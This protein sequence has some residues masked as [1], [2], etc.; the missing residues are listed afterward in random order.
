MNSTSDVLKKFFVYQ[1]FF[2]ILLLPQPVFSAEKSPQTNMNNLLHN[3]D[4]F[5]SDNLKK[6][7]TP[8]VAIAIA[9]HGKI[10]SLK[11]YGVKEAGK[12]DL[13]DK[14]TVFRIGSVSKGFAAILTGLLVKDGVLKWDDKVTKYL[15]EFSL[16]DKK[17][18]DNLTIRN[19]LDHTCGLVPHAYDSMIEDNVP[20]EK[21]VDK[22]SDLPV[23]CPVGECYGYQN[24]V[25]SLIG[26]IIKSATGKEYTELLSERILKPLGMN[27]VSFSKKQFIDSKN[28]ASPHDKI[29]RKWKPVSLKETYYSTTPSSG[30]N[31][32]IQDMAQWLLAM[33]GNKSDIIP[34]SVIDEVYTPCITTPRELRRFNRNH[35]IKAAYYGL[36]W[37]IFD[38]SGY[39]LVYH[40]G[41]VNG[42]YAVIALLPGQDTGIVVLQ[43]SSRHNYYVNKFLDMYLN[44][45]QDAPT[46]KTYR[47]SRHFRHKKHKRKKLM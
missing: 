21:I 30:I 44:I 36:G 47:V 4:A 27:T 9:D 23:E 37:R 24:V 26:D 10:V 34:L 7:R 19:I 17:N 43:N 6:S 15:P 20:F 12:P 39:K 29:K 13:I 1:L 35:R 31:C 42:Y 22:L 32:S 11:A 38:Y 14:K 3:Y 25:Y 28:Y 2:F 40:S 41:Y 46:K 33:L 8:G 5:V 18:T 16:H 45:R